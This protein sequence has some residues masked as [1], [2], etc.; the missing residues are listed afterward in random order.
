MDL[1]EARVAGSC[2]R[3]DGGK[4]REQ[5]SP[6]LLAPQ[7]VAIWDRDRMLWQ[8]EEG[9]QCLGH[10]AQRSPSLPYPLLNNPSIDKLSI[11]LYQ[12]RPGRFSPLPAIM[13][14]TLEMI[15]EKLSPNIISTTVPKHSW[16]D[17]QKT[18][19][20]SGLR[21]TWPIFLC[22]GSIRQEGEGGLIMLLNCRMPCIVACS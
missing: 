1:T 7:S 19:L 20:L 16:T 11:L 10:R 12:M 3:V 18:L 5:L 22:S 21:P 4:H 15:V 17:V 13:S 8:E 6:W 2:G 14:R 9:I